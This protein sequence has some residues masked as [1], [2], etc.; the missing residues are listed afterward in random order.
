M[1]DLSRSVDDWERHATSA[2]TDL[3]TTGASSDALLI[4]NLQQLRLYCSSF[5][6]SSIR[7]LSLVATS[8]ALLTT[9]AET[10][11]QS[12]SCRLG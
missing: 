5:F 7:D 8:S 6:F 11:W 3:L 2:F 12:L 10:G 4:E 9:L 1:R